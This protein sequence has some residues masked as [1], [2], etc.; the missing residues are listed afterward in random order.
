MRLRFLEIEAA[1]NAGHSFEPFSEV[2]E[3]VCAFAES[4]DRASNAVIALLTVAPW[5]RHNAA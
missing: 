1:S 5:R 2:H 3:S 4:G